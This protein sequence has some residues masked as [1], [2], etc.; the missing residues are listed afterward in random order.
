MITALLSLVLTAGAPVPLSLSSDALRAHYAG[1]RSLRADVVQVKEGKYW[2]R[3]LESRIRLQYVPGRVVWETLTPVRST[4][5]VSD[6]GMTV[7]G[8]DGRPRDM[9]PVTNDPR[10]AAIIRF[11][12]ALFAVDLP[13]I[14]RDFELCYAPG[15]LVAKPRPGS[16]VQ[17]FREV[18]LEFDDALELRNVELDSATERTRLTFSR[19][20]RDR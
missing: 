7:T 4:V 18:R 16:D 12:R 20:E 13:G 11:I 1:V 9:G 6:A 15:R 14:E 2:A 3:P 10:F 19:I 8:P 5:V 17:L